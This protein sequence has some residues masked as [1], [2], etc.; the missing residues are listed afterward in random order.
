MSRFIFMR[1]AEWLDNTTLRVYYLHLI[2]SLVGESV[3]LLP[4]YL[5]FKSEGKK[6]VLNVSADILVGM[7]RGCFMLREAFL[8]LE[9][10][11]STKMTVS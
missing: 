4:H 2:D 9:N 7:R 8:R 10:K 1:H 11:L 3:R 5:E 6:M